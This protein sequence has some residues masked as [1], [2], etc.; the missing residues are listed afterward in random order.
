[1]SYSAKVMSTIESFVS[2]RAIVTVCSYCKEA[3]MNIHVDT[4]SHLVPF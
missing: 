1:M 2:A 4:Y 3:F